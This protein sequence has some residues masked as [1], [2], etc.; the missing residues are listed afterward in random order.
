MNTSIKRNKQNLDKIND[1]FLVNQIFEIDNKDIVFLI[2]K[3]NLVAVRLK[4]TRTDNYDFDEKK[5]KE[6]NESLS[7]SFFNDFS[8]F[9][10]QNLALKHNLVTNYKESI[11]G[12][13]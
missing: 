8:N 4:K 13:L 10:I 3:N 2:S 6:L 11:V 12:I 7:K 1:P 5:Y 9:F